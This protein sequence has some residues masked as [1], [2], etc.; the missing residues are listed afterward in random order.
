MQ[1]AMTH[2]GHDVT[3]RDNVRTNQTALSGHQLTHDYNMMNLQREMGAQNYKDLNDLA[4][5]AYGEATDKAGAPN[6]A[7]QSFMNSLLTDARLE[8]RDPRQIDLPAMNHYKQ[9]YDRMQTEQPGI[10]RKGLGFVTGRPLS[11]DNSVVMHQSKKGTYKRGV[12][13][14]SY[15][16]QNGDTVYDDPMRLTKDAQRLRD[17]RD[18][19][20]YT[21]GDR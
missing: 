19:G 11:E 10:V 21:Q 3:E 2:E 5:G 1:N 4:D 16:N 9:E 13:G 17:L 15:Q 12:F 7:R 14:G 20:A 6:A 18:Q 8:G